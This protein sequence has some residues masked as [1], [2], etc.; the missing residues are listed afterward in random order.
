MSAPEVD[1]RETLVGEEDALDRLP[2]GFYRLDAT[3]R[4]VYANAAMARLYGFPDRNGFL[5]ADRASLY[6][7]AGSRAC[8]QA[9]GPP[10]GAPPV[11]VL[12][13]VRRDGTPFWVRETVVAAPDAAG[14]SW[15][16]EGILED[17]TAQ[18]ALAESER[19]HRRLVESLS[20]RYFFYR[21]DRRG[22]FTYLSPS[23]SRVLGYGAAAYRHH[24][25]DMLTSAAINDE[26][27]ART[28]RTL[29]G[30]QQ[31]PYAIEVRARDGS[32]RRLEVTE[33]P[34]RGALGEVRAVEGIARD[35]TEQWKGGEALRESEERYRA[36]VEHA[37]EA[38]VVVDARDGSTLVE[39]NERAVRLF[40]LPRELLLE[41]GA[42]GTKFHLSPPEQPDGRDSRAAAREV[43]RTALDGDA[44]SFEWTLRDAAGR[45]IPAEVRVVPHQTG[46]R[47]LLRSS[48][49][50]IS[51]RKR[52]DAMLVGQGRI[53]EKIATD[54]PLEDTLADLV[55]LVESQAEG[56]LGSVV[57][58]DEDGARLRGVVAPTLPEAYSRA[59]EGL[60]IGP[61]AGSCGT[62]MFLGKR[63]VV[64]D[65]QTDPLWEDHRHLAAPYGLRACWSMPILSRHG[66]VLGAFAI[67]YRQPRDPGAAELG[68]I[69]VGTHIA[70]IAIESRRAEDALRASEEK[71]RALFEEGLA[72]HYVATPSGTLLV[73]NLSFARMA[74]F[75]SAGAAAGSS[76]RSR[77]PDGERWD[78][79]L[80][81][82]R[83]KR[84][85]ENYEHELRRSDGATL[86][87]I[88]NAVGQFDERGELLEIHGYV[89]DDTQRTRA[90]EA[91]RQAQKIEAVGQLAGG[92]AHD[93]NNL[94]SVV[95]GYGQLLSRDLAPGHRGHARLEQIQKAVERAATLTRQLLAFSRKQVLEPKVLDLSAVV[96]NVEGMLRRLIGE[97]IQ[98]VTV[99]DRD[100]TLA[101]VDPGQ[102]EQVIVN[103]AVNARDAMPGGG[104][105]IV[106]TANV[107]LDAAFART[108][109]GASA[110]HHVLL[111]VSDTGHGMDAA[112]LSRVFEP[113]FT[114]KEQGKGTGLGLSTV[115]GI[116]KQSGGYIDVY[117]E[118]GQ[119]STFRIY[120][121]RV[122][123]AEVDAVPRARPDLAPAPG[124]SETILLLEDEDSLREVIR[125]FLEEAG[126]SVIECAGAEQA[127]AAVE[128]SDQ[129]LDLMLTDVVMP[130][131]SGPQV[132]ER[133][134]LRRPGLKVVYMS[135][136]TDAAIS[137]HGVLDPGTEF[138]AKPFT[139]DAIRRKI[140]E[141]LDRG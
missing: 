14:R 64:S 105:L 91:L 70:G 35:I 88:E 67:Y 137:H 54:A 81:R 17:V 2:V 53:L 131:M 49:T 100:V 56:L 7:G 9:A 66:K 101:R 38:I 21:H 83:R 133:A 20:E 24:Y 18:E 103:L 29:Q 139:E 92:I 60:P 28:E 84:R 94:M 78:A 50:D 79:F 77:Y 122:E 41:P 136:Y 128:S 5:E 44:Q 74:G 19:S 87:V 85:L 23:V 129:P 13:Q 42:L 140:R 12:R 118:P 116:V 43:L 6:P 48:I 36:L 97:H 134:R 89:V 57:L 121:P 33:F 113:F 104:R 40:G 115:Y 96:V 22:Q 11:R 26:V 27:V 71:Y 135:G 72:G 62:A 95:A 4:L 138:L 117:S 65:I 3:G 55:R 30:E 69:D 114:T 123:V 32:L 75:E 63:V 107:E 111:A 110:G 51:E 76:L 45:D 1:G 86:R 73:C 58:L 59:L 8:W 102:M 126:Y 112:I 130:H 80:D 99:F 25:A 119:G 98:L 82:L 132:A 16:Y 127:L 90:E 46:G 52:A 10:S 125:E 141:V 124:G 15:L 106:E 47:L 37:P 39:V 108:R 109:P 31:A 93:F 34:V 120:L 61:R 68:L